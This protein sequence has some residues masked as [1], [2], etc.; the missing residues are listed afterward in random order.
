MNTSNKKQRTLLLK[1]E[2]SLG[3][4]CKSQPIDGLI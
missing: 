4:V 3:K 1:K 2:I